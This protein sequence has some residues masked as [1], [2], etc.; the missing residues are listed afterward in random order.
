MPEASLLKRA[1]GVMRHPALYALWQ[2]PFKHAKLAPVERHT[3]LRAVRS[4]LDVGC[5]PGT[6]AARFAHARYVGIDSNADY[7]AAARKRFEGTFLVADARTFAAPGERFDCILVNSLLH[8]IDTANVRSMLRQ[9]STQLTDDGFIHVIDLVLPE[10]RSIARY[11][12]RSDRGDHARSLADWR[13]LFTEPF[14]EDVLEPFALRF[15]GLT[16]W[17]LVYFKGHARRPPT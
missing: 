16:P 17:Q 5:G 7:I 14:A 10:N 6:N 12:A 15:L 9:L 1:S 11:M 13:R 4:V 8:H 3:D 2:A